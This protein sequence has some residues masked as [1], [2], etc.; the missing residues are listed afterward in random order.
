VELILASDTAALSIQPTD[1]DEVFPCQA[2]L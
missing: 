1:A 2:V